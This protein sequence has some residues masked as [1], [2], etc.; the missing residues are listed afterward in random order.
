MDIFSFV[1]TVVLV[2]VSG[3]LAPGPL[4]FTV[5]SHGMKS[6]AKGG[7]A[8]SIGHTLFEFLLVLFLAFILNFGVKQVVGESVI[9][10]SVGIV[11]GLALIAFGAIQIYESVKPKTGNQQKEVK[12]KSQKV[13][14]LLVLGL[15]FTGLNPFFIV[16]WLT[17]GLLL[18][19][20]AL[21]LASFAGVLVMYVA[22]VWMDYAWLTGTAYLAKRG[23][24]ILG[25]KGYRILV[26]VFG[27]VLIC[28]GT[29]FLVSV[30]TA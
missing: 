13:R 22:H 27:A 24:N 18:I 17:A 15:A 19:E 6:G 3:A 8:F 12:E 10:L 1:I 26:A 14:H 25:S 29:Y 20:Q 9:R 21:A 23:A 11:G 5:I 4:F 30:L 7:L 16:W 2:T 28:F